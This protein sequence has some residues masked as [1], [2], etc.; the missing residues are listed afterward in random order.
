MR[1]RRALSLKDMQTFSRQVMQ[2]R[3]SRQQSNAVTV[4]HVQK[5]VFQADGSTGGK[6]QVLSMRGSLGLDGGVP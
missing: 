4:P 3:R 1:H 5:P 2:E 6:E